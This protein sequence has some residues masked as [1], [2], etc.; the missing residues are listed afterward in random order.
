MCWKRSCDAWL[1]ACKAAATPAETMSWTKAEVTG[2]SAADLPSEPLASF[3]G[4]EFSVA[5]DVACFSASETADAAFVSQSVTPLPAEVAVCAGASGRLGAGQGIWLPLAAFARISAEEGRAEGAAA[6][7][8]VEGCM[9]ALSSAAPTRKLPLRKT[10]RPARRRI[11]QSGDQT[12]YGISVLVSQSRA[13]RR[14]AMVCYSRGK[15][16]VGR[17]GSQVTALESGNS[18]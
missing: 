1:I 2:R 15:E 4:R 18:S 11:N 6:S 12:I 9:L 14:E 13:S 5:A 3:S 17:A 8:T 7:G 16:A 10:V